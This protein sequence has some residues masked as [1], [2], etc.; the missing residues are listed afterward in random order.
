MRRRS[1]FMVFPAA[2]AAAQ[3]QESGVERDSQ[4]NR[5]RVPGT[6]ELHARRRQGGRL[7]ETVLRWD[8]AQTAII[9]C[10]MWDAHTCSSSAQRVAAMAPRMNRSLRALAAWE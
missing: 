5:T 10:D 3:G 8:V 7:S 2:L 4:Q 6:L 1:F 9:I